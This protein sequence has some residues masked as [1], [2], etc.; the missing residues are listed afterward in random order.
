MAV[1]SRWVRPFTRQAWWPRPGNGFDIEALLDAADAQAAPVERH[2]WLIRLLDWVRRGEPVSGMQCVVRLLDAHAHPARR[3]RV[4][5]L[6]AAVWRDTDVAALLSD[7]GFS[8]R[9]A[10]LNELGERLRGRVLPQSPET[11]DL[12]VLFGLLFSDADDA[13]WLAALDAATLDGIGALWQDA[14]AHDATP[15]GDPQRAPLGWRDAFYDAMLY[16]ATQVRAIGFSPAFRGR[17]G[18]SVSRDFDVV[19]ADPNDGELGGQGD[20][21]TRAAF[22]QLTH[23]IERMRD[24]ALAIALAPSPEAAQAPTAT[25]LQEAQY[26]R[27]LLDT[28]AEA[29]RGL[30]GHLDTQGISVN[31]VFQ[32]DQLC[33]RCRRIALLLDVVLAPQP[34]PAL[35]RLVLTLVTIGRDRR[36]VRALFSQHTS[37]LARRVAERSAE[38]GEHYITRTRA[39][40]MNMLARASGGGAVLA[41]TTFMKFV[42]LSLGLSPFMAGFGA[43][44]NY[45]VS[46]VLVQW[47]HFTV[48]TKQPAMTAPA[49]ATK[50]ADVHSDEAVEGFVDEVAHLLRSQM[51]GI[52]GNLMVVAPLVLGVQVLAWWVNGRPLVNAH[53]AHHVLETLTLLGPTLWY[54]AFTGV[55]LFASSILAGWAENA[56]VLHR[57]DSALR[58][59]PHIQAWLGEARAARWSAWWRENVS[60][61]AA[62][63]SLGLMLG[64]VP[65]VA[66]FLGLPLDVRHVTLSTGQVA[67]AIGTLGLPVLHEPQLWW[68]VAALPLTGVLNVG[69]SFVLALRVAVRSRGVR[70]TDRARLWRAVLRRL[71]RQPGSFL[72]PPR[73]LG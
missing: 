29:A 39:E 28:C 41:G 3:E 9:A 68:C 51:A 2:I 59:N 10:F 13:D 8:P 6:L 65:V 57:L 12:A 58:F 61:L 34:G 35:H 66:H 67:A 73:S 55:L 71:W 25:L 38:T 49:M 46:F 43:G 22:R 37:Q 20:A 4:V 44:V 21:S 31:L 7:F 54:A 36:S 62:N 60:G 5:A 30:H 17:M 48:A 23:V 24:H 69:V 70:V 26:L 11:N 50:L 63:I 33:E 42:V 56:F 18:I 52:V 19:G 40:Y 53:E 64:I 72:L 16:L 45:A 32:I 27:V 14:L 1:F 47:L 15:F